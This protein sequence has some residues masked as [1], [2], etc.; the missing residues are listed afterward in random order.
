VPLIS[1]PLIDKMSIVRAMIRSLPCLLFRNATLSL[2]E[3]VVIWG[4]ATHARDDYS[5]DGSWKSPLAQPL[6]LQS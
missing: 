2:S 6:Y 3:S 1:R 5:G 4:A